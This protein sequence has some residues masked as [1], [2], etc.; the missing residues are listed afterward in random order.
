VLSGLSKVVGLP[1]LKLGWIH[2]GGAEPLRTVAQERLEMIAD[3][4]L[5]VS[6]PVQLATPRLLAEQPRV[7]AAIGARLRENLDRLRT[8]VSG[9]PLSVLPV[10]GGWYAVVRLP[11]LCSEEEWVLTLFERDGLLCHP[12]YVFDFPEEA[13]IVLSLLAPPAELA[14]GLTRLLARTRAL[15]L[16]DDALTE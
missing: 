1:Q 14:E 5:S 15:E 13:Y 12:G 10:E 3:T 11:R 16:R 6:T 4:F 2:V 7:A 8:A 9:S